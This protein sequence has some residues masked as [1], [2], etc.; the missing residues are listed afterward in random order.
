MS[1]AARP[2]PNS[3]NKG[4]AI[5]LMN[6]KVAIVT[7]GASGIGQGI[8]LA[9]AREGAKVA[10]ADLNLEGAQAVAKRIRD[11]GG[12]AIG[13]AM[14]VTSEEEVILVSHSVIK[15]AW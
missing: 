3:F 7:G 10:I 14:N 1:M 12:Q 4:I 5:M 2:L 11:A 15:N 13:V 9:F 8:A 6:D